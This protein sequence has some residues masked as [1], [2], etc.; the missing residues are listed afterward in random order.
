[1]EKINSKKILLLYTSGEKDAPSK[2]ESEILLTSEDT[3]HYPLG[4]AY[5]YSILEKEGHEI[6]LLSLVNNA[7]ND[8]YAKIK[9][10]LE[11]FAPDIV[12]FQIL[13]FNRAST[14]RMMEYINE[15]YPNMKQVIGGVHATI[16]HRQIIEKYPFAIAAL[17][18]GELTIV[19]LVNQL[20]KPDCDLHAVKGITFSGDGEVVTTAPREL[21]ANLDDIP[22]PKH[23]IFFTGERTCGAL[24]TTRGCP[25]RCSFC[26]LKAIS[27]GRVRMRSVENII[28]EVEMMVQ[29]FPK[30]TEIFIHDDTFFIDNLRVIKFCDE[31]IKRN[32]KINFSCNARVKPMSKEMVD[33]LEKANFKRVHLGIESGDNEILRRCHKGINQEDITRAFEILAKTK[34]GVYSFLII[35]LPGENIDTIMETINFLKKLQKIKYSP[36][37]EQAGILK[38][39]PG[40]EVYEIAK[41]AGFIDDDYWLTDKPI[42]IFTLENSYTRLKE[43]EKIFFL[44]LSQVAA[45]CTWTGFKSQFTIIPYHLKNIFSNL[46]STKSFF[47]RVIKFIL[48]ENIYKSLKK[49]WKLYFHKLKTNKINF[50]KNHNNFIKKTVAFIKY[51][52]NYT[53][54]YYLKYHFLKALQ[55]FRKSYN[56]TDDSLSHAPVNDM[57]NWS[58]Y[59][60]H[61][62]GEMFENLKNYSINLE[63]NDYIYE[64]NQLIKNDQF[65]KSIHENWRLIYE[66]ILDLKPKKVFEL[67]CGNGMHLHNIQKLNPDIKLFAIDRDKKQIEY[68][69]ESYP[70]LNAE[71]MERDAT[72]QFPQNLRSLVDLSF[73]QAVIMHLYTGNSHLEALANLFNVSNKHVLLMERWKN[74]NIMEDIKNLHQQKKIEWD[75]IFFYYKN[76]TE[77]NKPHLMICSKEILPYPELTDY[78]VFP[79]N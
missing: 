4:L 58:L 20:S 54:P 1:M 71:I 60:I 22:F 13:T 6:H 8:C 10:E 32:I 53:N 46:S 9:K 45:F 2:V 63:N 5:L 59:N 78:N 65:K 25:S 7:E 38:I 40:T 29:K 3:T 57:F 75:K 14:F 36:S 42:P 28:A 35:G 68:L 15:I 47:I 41:A 39:F 24:F 72:I 76:S 48:P 74:H 66:T 12:C 50:Y 43:Y 64:N 69:N 51:P 67:G 56:L 61:Y 31:I 16:M 18:E 33:K 23:E 11:S 62:R 37:C 30:M 70:D 44:H 49:S 79:K 26:C 77:T 55:K 73:T 17:A 52:K 19:D 34:I 21:I 27:L